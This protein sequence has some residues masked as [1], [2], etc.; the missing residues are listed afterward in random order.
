VPFG[1][2]HLSL[3]TGV[4]GENP[5]NLVNVILQGLPAQGGVARPIMPGFASILDD[6]QIVDL[7]THL[8]A[9]FGQ[10]PS[11]PGVEDAIREARVQP[12]IAKRSA[13]KI[14]R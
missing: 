6:R 1:G 7:V 8:R 11:W 14:E 10:K 3:S 9:R 2:I 4:A 13:S 5:E 12:G